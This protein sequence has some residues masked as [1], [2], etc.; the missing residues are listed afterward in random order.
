MSLF[1]R[2][3]PEHTIETQHNLL[4]MCMCKDVQQPTDH[5][6]NAG[7]LHT[8]FYP[9][10]FFGSGVAGNTAGPPKTRKCCTT[11]ENLVIGNY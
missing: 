11:K 3:F 1:D 7:H 8:Q 6:Y 2:L 5:D 4:V 10:T 9:P